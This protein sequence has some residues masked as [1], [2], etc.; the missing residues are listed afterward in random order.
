[1]FS[2]RDLKVLSGPREMSLEMFRSRYFTILL[3]NKLTWCSGTPTVTSNPDHC[4]FRSRD[5]NPLYLSVTTYLHIV[6]YICLIPRYYRMV[7]RSPV[8]VA[9]DQKTLSHCTLQSRDPRSLYLMVEKPLR[10]APYEL[11]V[12]GSFRVVF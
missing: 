12:D 9:C 4:T 3:E 5:P 6:H 10:I 1:M 7:L 2:L 11:K 8:I